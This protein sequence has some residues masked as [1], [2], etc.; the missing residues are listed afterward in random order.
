MDRRRVLKWLLSLPLSQILPFESRSG[1][2]T[3]DISA[4]DRPWTA[5][6]FQFSVGDKTLPGIA[7]RTAGTDGQSEPESLFVASRVCPHERCELLYFKDT[8]QLLQIFRV[9][10]ENPVLACPCHLSVFDLG[11]GGKVINGPAPRPPLRLRYRVEGNKL[12]VLD[13]EK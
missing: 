8:D 7:I 12:T 11:Q 10:A 2:I 9:K 5:L 3:V 4:L 6:E 1:E 13:L